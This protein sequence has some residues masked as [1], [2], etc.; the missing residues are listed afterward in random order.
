MAGY[1]DTRELIINTLMGRPA[2]TEIQPEDHQAFALQITEYIR[3]V[4]L[5]AGSGVPVAFAE[6]DTVPVQPDNGQAVYL[7]Y[8][9]RNVTK[10]FVNF[11]NQSGN[12]I[13]VTSSSGEVKLV[14]LLWNGSYW[15]SQIVTIDVLS[16]DSSVN[17]SNIGASDYILFSTSSNYSIGDVVRYDGKLYK[18]TAEHAAGTW[19]GTDVELASINSILTSKLS[20]LEGNIYDKVFLDTVLKYDNS[21]GY[22]YYVN[23]TLG[24]N[25]PSPIRGNYWAI[26]VYEV[27]AGMEYQIVIPK[28]V[29]SSVC[30]NVSFALTKEAVSHDSLFN[31]DGTTGTGNRYE[32][33]YIP[34]QNGFILISFM[35]STVDGTVMYGEPIVEYQQSESRIDKLENSFARIFNPNIVKVNG[36]DDISGSGK[37]FSIETELSLEA[38]LV[39]PEKST[40]C[41]NGGSID[42]N[43]YSVDFNGCYLDGSVSLI[44][45]IPGGK[46]SNLTLN[47]NM[48]GTKSVANSN[49]VVD[50]FALASMSGSDLVLDEKT[51]NITK[52]VFVYNKVNVVGNGCTFNVSGSHDFAFIFGTNKIKGDSLAWEGSFSHVNINIIAGRFNQI[53]GLFNACNSEIAYCNI[54]C[55]RPGAECYNKII[56]RVNNAN[57]VVIDGTILNNYHIHHNTTRVSVDEE[58]TDKNNCECIGVEGVTNVNIEFNTIWNTMDDLGVHNCQNVRISHN[59]L[60]DAY[61]GRIFCSNS[62]DVEIAYNYIYYKIKGGNGI[63]I[64]HEDVY[65][66]LA[67]RYKIIGNYV[68]YL[69]IPTTPNVWAGIYIDGARYV[70]VLGNT[71]IGNYNQAKI[72]IVEHPKSSGVTFDTHAENSGYL[73]PCN[74]N[75]EKNSVNSIF[76]SCGNRVVDN[77]MVINNN[78]KRSLFLNNPSI[79]I[80]GNKIEGFFASLSHNIQGCY[81]DFRPSFIINKTPLT[82][83]EGMLLDGHITSFI[84]PCDLVWTG[85]FSS[86]MDLE[87]VTGTYLAYL[88]VDDVKVTDGTA[89]ITSCIEN[90]ATNAKPT[91][92]KRGSKISV[93]IRKNVASATDATF[94]SYIP[95]MYKN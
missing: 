28:T 68:N 65:Q 18:F 42:G 11:I 9:P 20:E 23:T 52:P 88:Y 54:D 80:G 46:V 57:V 25:R 71:L 43:G 58:D 6:P 87:S 17:A 32:A 35:Y 14:T 16:D 10:N 85:R 90:K 66:Q 76:Y 94:I 50:A 83:E 3:Q 4:E 36:V 2:D 61:D 49:Y 63:Y 53:I 15:S 73:V 29:D 89:T 55:S 41:F 21:N 67:E 86:Y 39:I 19:I 44:D 38:D 24:V 91:I 75:I 22:S 7:S 77:V 82:T 40:L 48:F 13:S 64:G 34:E 62:K 5:V 60:N 45:V 47:I 59:I 95:L 70:D 69:D 31:T 33:K 72:S 93:K 37:I 1:A 78:I 30:R 51:Y 92:I 12:S 26:N 27:M 74:L 8:V 81:A 56:G 79:L 84:A